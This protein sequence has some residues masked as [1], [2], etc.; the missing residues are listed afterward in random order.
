MPAAGVHESGRLMIPKLFM[1]H[2]LMVQ[3][4]KVIFFEPF[5]L[6]VAILLLLYA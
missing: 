1:F 5:R 2:T 4:A 6:V 3:P